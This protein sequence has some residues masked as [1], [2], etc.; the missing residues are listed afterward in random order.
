MFDSLKKEHIVAHDDFNRWKVPPASIAIHLCIGSVYAWSIFN[1]RLTKEFGVVAASSGDWSLQSVVWIFSVAI[2]FLGLAAAFGGKWL[3]EVGPRMVGVVAALC[4]GGGFIIGGAGI[5]T[6]QLWL[7]YL[8]Y[9][10]IG[11]CGLGLGY[12]SPVSTLIRWFPDRRGMA[13]GMAI[14]GFG[15]GAMIATPIKETLLGIFYKAPQYL[16]AEG[17][18]NLV[19]EGGKR[20]AEVNGHMVEVVVASAKQLASAPVPLQEGVYV[21]GTGN[22]GAAMTFFTLGIGYFIVMMI[23]SFSYRVP[24]EGWVPAGWTPPTAEAAS[25]KMITQ[26]DVHI[27][28]ALRTP[29]FYLLWIVLCFNVTAGIGVIGVAKTMMTEIFGTTLPLIVNSS[30]AATYVFMISVFNMVGRF[31]W[32][33]T[34]DFIGRKNTYHIFFVLGIVLYLSIPYAAQ[35]VSVN[36]VVTWLVMFY[37]ATMIIFTMYGGG[38][39]TIPAY[40]ADIFG[41]KYVGGIHGRLLTAWSTAG[42]LGP[43][44]ITRLRG[45]SVGN[46]IRD[47]AAKVDPAAF[48]AKFGAGMDQLDQLVAAKT[49]TIARLMEIAPAGTVDPTS[50]LYNTTM[51]AMAALLAIA[52]VA[53]SLVRPVHEKHHMEKAV[54]PAAAE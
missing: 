18:V 19:T 15:G 49:V 38:F 23:A 13:T 4:W 27:D 47:L 2:V 5:V 52:L 22:T 50:S 41:T 14:M 39:A 9:G 12:V 53:N 16:G 45:V 32:A 30:F 34:S 42:V 37:A 17:A 51:Y 35:Q 36:P 40:L 48:Q 6:H 46:S 3:E 7:V 26:N 21:A 20:M 29:Q 10:V 25:R 11:G 54:S 1:P 31:F 33:S 8:G 43:L 24:R 28:Q 44:A